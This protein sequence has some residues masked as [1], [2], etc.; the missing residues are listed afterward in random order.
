MRQ[1]PL[2][3]LGVYYHQRL[4]YLGSQVGE[5]FSYPTRR[6]DRVEI[7]FGNRSSSEPKRCSSCFSQQ[8]LLHPAVIRRLHKTHKI[9]CA[10]TFASGEVRVT[11]GKTKHF[12]DIGLKGKCIQNS[13]HMRRFYPINIMYIMNMKVWCL[14]L[15]HDKTVGPIGM[16]FGKKISYK[17]YW[18]K[19]Y[20]WR[21]LPNFS[22]IK[23]ID[24]TIYSKNIF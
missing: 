3:G 4:W 1:W 9:R 23:I 2:C 17:L 19:K 22:K 15:F 6:E 18:H 10:L 8:F 12:Q 13:V 24:I 14:L 21:E 11:F 20:F 16:K 5:N 7:S